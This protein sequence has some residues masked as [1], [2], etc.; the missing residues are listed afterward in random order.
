MVLAVITMA[1]MLSFGLAT[2]AFGTGQRHLA[3]GERVRDS[4]F[5]VAEGVLNSEV[6]LLGRS[7]PTN[8]ASAYPASC[9]SSTTVTNCPDAATISAQ[10]S[11]AQ[12]ANATWTA[13]VQDN[14]GTVTAYYSTT[15][16]A[17][18]PAYDANG[19]GKVWVRAR[20]V[21]AG[22]PRTLITQ[23]QAQLQPLPFPKNT[24]TAGYVAAGSNGKK[25]LVD[26]NGRSY[27]TTPGQAGSVAVR[28]ANPPQSSCLDLDLSKGQLSPPSYQTGYSSSSIVTAAQLSLMRATAQSYGT[29]Y[30]SGCPGSLTG[31]LVFIENANC[32]YSN[33]TGN[34]LAAPGVVVV[35]TGTLTLTGAATYYG[36]IYAGNGQNSTGVVVNLQGCSKVIGSLVVEGSGGA[37]VGSCGNNLAY[38]AS[39]TTLV[40]VYGDP[41]VVKSTWRDIAG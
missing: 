15:G 35:A 14:G 1:V 31:T 33:G 41:A 20:A 37:Q 17:S 18:Q 2:I 9:S 12:Y 19:D 27:T 30:A 3:S 38:N 8:S 28:C 16:A 40:K 11:D 24:V 6:F 22:I 13:N 4:A 10:F 29:Y 5:N 21:V 26:T 36:L 25:V 23:V 32:S 34:S 7:W 39:V